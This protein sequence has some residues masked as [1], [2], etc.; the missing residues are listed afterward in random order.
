MFDLRYHVAS[1]TAVFLALVIG[2]VVGVGIS[3]SV[4]KGEKSL[5]RAQQHALQQNLDRAQARIGALS[6]QQRGAAA[7]LKETYRS[8]MHNR[9]KRKRIAVLYVG[10]NPQPRPAALHDAAGC[11]RQRPGPDPCAP[12]SD[13]PQASRQGPRR[14]ADARRLQGRGPAR[15]SRPRARPGARDRRG[16]TAVGRALGAARGVPRGRLGAPGRR[17]RRRALGQPADGTDGPV[18]ARSLQRPRRAPGCPPS[19]SRRRGRSRPRSRPSRTTTSRPSTTST[20]RSGA[21]RSTLLLDGAKPG[22]YGM[23]STASGPLPPLAPPG[24]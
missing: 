19:A 7:Y 10:S 18:P 2:I 22:N 20:S 3:G 4:D 14:P 8:V 15:R 23:K 13:R 9:L 17:R 1:L 11:R 6:Q 24:G 5:A 12:G 16:H 21:T